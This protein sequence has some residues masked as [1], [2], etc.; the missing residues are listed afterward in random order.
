ESV[1]FDRHFADDPSPTGFTNSCPPT[2]LQSLHDAGITTAFVDDRKSR[3]PEIRDWDLLL[4]TEPASCST[5]GDALISVFESALDRLSAAP[6]WLLW[7]ETDRL[8]PPWDFDQET[9]EHYASATARFTVGD[10][11]KP[12]PIPDRITEPE[13]GR[14][15]PDEDSTWHRLHNSFAAAVTSFDAELDVLIEVLR[16]RG[17][18]QTAAWICTSGYGWPLGE[19]GAIGPN[20]SRMHTELVHL[21][22]LLR[23]LKAEQSMRRVPVFTQASDL[24]PTLL[25]LFGLSS[26]ARSLLPLATGSMQVG[27][28]DARSTSIRSK[29]VQRAIRTP[30]WAFLPAVR[31]ADE[32]PRLYRKPDDIWEVNDLAPRHPDECDR[33]AAL[34][35]DTTAKEP[36]P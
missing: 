26:A 18:D 19:H 22:L 33:L 3:P 5:P 6:H 2:L 28:P 32:P 12:P 16:E 9:Y 1:V 4:P 21:P 29:D 10:E 13:S 31:E 8:L 34:L 30:E 24:S 20:E 11:D 23:L 25:D 27:R 7:V 17:L 36:T 35:D 15:A 14:V